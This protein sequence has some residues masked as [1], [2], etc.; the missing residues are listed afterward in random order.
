MLTIHK[1]KS[2]FAM[3]LSGA[4]LVTSCNKDPEQFITPE[5]PTPSGDMLG[6]VLASS[7]SDSLYNRLV[8][9]AGMSSMINNPANQYTMFVPG[10]NA[11]KQFINAASGGLVPLNAPDAVFSGFI[12]TQITPANAAMIVGYNTIP[13]DVTFASF[14]TSFPNFQYPTLV[15]PAPS[16]SALL[17]LTT[18]PSARNGNWVNNVPVTVT[19][20]V[21]GN[22]KIHN[23]AAMVVPP[24]RFIWD[25]INTDTDLEYFKAA[26]LRADSATNQG[27][28]V[29]GTLQGYLSN[30]GANFTVFA[31][32]D[33]AFVDI[34]T[35]AIT[36]AL[37]AQGVPLAVAQAQATALASSP[38]VFQN[39]AL[40]G[41]LTAERVQGILVYH[42]MMGRAFTNNLPTTAANFPT[43][44]NSVFA[45][46]PGVRL[47]VTMGAP[48]A[49]AATVKGA[50]N[51]TPANIQINASPLLPD[52]N[53]TS[54]QH[55]LNGVLH[56]IDQVLL[57]LPL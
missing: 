37:V 3:L 4:L 24:S 14:G 53:G 17:R 13:Q 42:I 1:I 52:P 2:G 7:D 57:P 10:N 19:D 11:M 51:P 22:G 31:P 18:F 12:Q 6:T 20:R 46:H 30:I 39:P 36:Q 32:T 55:Y 8:I 50:E 15:N 47:E 48:F 25:R 27:G 41:V 35:G 34:L 40:F 38:T 49:T 56:K 33:Q 26:L 16:V 44:L 28:T 21:A 23:V 54:D 45:A 5:P 43:L 9:H 29:P